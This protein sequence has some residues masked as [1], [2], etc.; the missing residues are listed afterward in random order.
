MFSLKYERY[1][2][3]GDPKWTFSWDMPIKVSDILKL[4]ELQAF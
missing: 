3:K 4:W 2:V 1:L